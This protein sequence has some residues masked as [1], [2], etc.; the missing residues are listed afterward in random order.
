MMVQRQKLCMFGESLNMMGSDVVMDTDRC[1]GGGCENVSNGN[2]SLTE[3]DSQESSSISHFTDNSIKTIGSQTYRSSSSS[4]SSDSEII[5]TAIS[6]SPCLKTFA[7]NTKSRR[8]GAETTTVDRHELSYEEKMNMIKL[9]LIRDVADCLVTQGEVCQTSDPLHITNGT[10]NEFDGPSG[11]VLKGNNPHCHSDFTLSNSADI[12]YCAIC[13]S[14]YQIGELIS[15]N[16][17]CNH[18]FHE[19]CLLKW[20]VNFNKCPCCSEPFLRSISQKKCQ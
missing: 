3:L 15:V 8:T 14:Y 11:N 6:T 10:S 2:L 12:S 7:F 16:P 4:S 13:Q 5:P 20:L 1:L 17:Y 9:L 19:M 18:I